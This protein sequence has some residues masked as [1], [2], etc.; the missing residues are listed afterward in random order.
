MKINFKN[1]FLVSALTVA[2]ISLVSSRSFAD[3]VRCEA[4]AKVLF[5]EQI[6]FFIS[7]D[8]FITT[9]GRKLHAIDTENFIY[10]CDELTE[11]H[12]KCVIYA[13]F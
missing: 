2:T 12:A 11:C 7:K 6:D 5:E 3:A 1:I 10:E 4:A 13:S 8:E 9:H